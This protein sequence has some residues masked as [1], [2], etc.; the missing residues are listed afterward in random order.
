MKVSAF[1]CDL[2]KAE[3]NAKIEEYNNAN[4]AHDTNW[5]VKILKIQDTHQTSYESGVD[6]CDHTE[7]AVQTFFLVL[8]RDAD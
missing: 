6:G 2:T 4:M 5:V 3:V 8:E 7:D 1:F